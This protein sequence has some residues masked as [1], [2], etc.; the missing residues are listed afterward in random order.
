[1]RK[2]EIGRLGETLAA[3]YMEKKGYCIR[4]RNCRLGHWELDL[5]CE[6]E[7]HLIFVEVK[8]RTDTGAPSRYGRPAC[9]VDEKK[10]LFLRSA[11]Q[12]YLR[13]HPSGKKKRIDVIEVYLTPQGALTAKGIHHIENALL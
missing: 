5:V 13:E 11:A 8:T 6:N 1:M 4:A 2:I 10:K 9:A 7:T 3:E 12:A